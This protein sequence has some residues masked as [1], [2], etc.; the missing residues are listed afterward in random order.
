[1]I[2]FVMDWC[3]DDNHGYSQIQRWGPD[4]DC[5]S[6]QYM[7][8]WLEGITSPQTACVSVCSVTH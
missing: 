3:S 4:C 2:D 1:M 6:L 5:A 7:G 8:L